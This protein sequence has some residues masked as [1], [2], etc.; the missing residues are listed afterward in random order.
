LENSKSSGALEASFASADILERSQ[1][2][3]NLQLQARLGK[4][5]EE[6]ETLE[7]KVERL[8]KRYGK[9]TDADVA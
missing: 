3:R 8:E 7:D 2:Q 6:H 1:S 9:V 4:A 5:E